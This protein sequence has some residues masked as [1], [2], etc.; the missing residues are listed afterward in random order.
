MTHPK[1]QSTNSRYRAWLGDKTAESEKPRQRI[2]NADRKVFANPESFA[3]EAHYWLKNL[4]IFEKI[5]S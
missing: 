3:Q 2:S 5:S 4:R 1:D